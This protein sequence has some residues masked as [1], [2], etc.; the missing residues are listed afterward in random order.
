MQSRWAPKGFNWDVAR[1]DSAACALGNH[2]PVT[3]LQLVNM[4]NQSDSG[5][6]MAG[7]PY[8][9]AAG[10]AKAC[11]PQM[12]DRATLAPFDARNPESFGLSDPTIDR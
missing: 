1:S 6:P 11:I 2:A 10:E 12:T 8:D 7:V 4:A 3:H 9:G 5:G